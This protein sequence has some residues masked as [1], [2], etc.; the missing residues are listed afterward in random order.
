MVCVP[1]LKNR[2]QAAYV[3]CVTLSSIRTSPQTHQNFTFIQT[4]A[5]QANL[6]LVP[7]Y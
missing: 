6:M 5:K 7:R 3:N 2:S 1:L 4:V